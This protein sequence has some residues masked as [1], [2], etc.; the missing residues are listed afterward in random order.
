MKKLLKLLVLIL[1][2]FFLSASMV[3]AGN[4]AVTPA[5]AISGRVIDDLEESEVPIVGARVEA[6]SCAEE[7]PSGAAVTDKEGEYVLTIGNGCYHLRIDGDGYESSWYGDPPLKDSAAD[8]IVAGERVTGIDASISPAGSLITGRVKGEDGKPLSGAWVTAFQLEGEEVS[9][10]DARSDQKGFF[11]IRV[12]PGSYFLIFARRGYVTRVHGKSLEDPTAV[13]VLAGGKAAGI[14]AVLAK[15]GRITGTLTDAGGKAVDGI[16]VVADAVDKAMI[17]VTTRSENGQFVL[18]GLPTGK[19][20]IAFVD[21]EQHYYPQWHDGKTNPEEAL[22]IGVKAPATTSGIKGVLRQAG[23]ISGRVTNAAGNALPEVMVF[24][25][26]TD[27]SRAVGKDLTDEMGEYSIALPTGSYLVSFRTLSGA[28]LPRFYPDGTDEQTAHPVAVTAP[29]RTFGID[30]VLPEGIFLTG[31]VKDA[32]GEPIPTAFIAAYPVDSDD[33]PAGFTVVEEDGNFSLSLPEGEYV[34]EFTSSSGYLSQWSGGHAERSQ[35]E[36]VAIARDREPEAVNVVLDRGGSISGIVKNSMGIG[37]AGVSVS[38]TNA[39]TGEEGGSATSDEG[40]AFIIEGLPTA[41]FYLT[42]TGSEAGYVRVR[43]PQPVQVRAPASTERVEIIMKNGGAIA[44]RIVDR[45]GNP[46]QQVTVS[47]HDPVTWDEIGS[48]ETDANGTYQI[49]GLP[50]NFYRIRFEK[51]LFKVQWFKGKTRREDST[52]VEVVGTATVSSIDAILDSGIPLTGK[53][54]DSA[55]VPLYGAD[56]EIYG[57]VEDEPFDRVTTDFQGQFTVPTLAAGSY[58]VRFGH[59]NHVPQ[60]YGGRDRRTAAPVVITETFVPVLSAALVKSGGMV[61]GKLSS[62]EGDDI[63]EAWLTVLDAATGIA[64]ADERICECSGEFDT[65]VPMGRYRLR[66]ERH[67]QISWYGGDNQ[68]NATVLPVNGTVGRL[69]MI[70]K[71]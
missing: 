36:T 49:G 18:D 1:V 46:M 27:G 41:L 14:D 64:V 9:I 23:G 62:P 54:T 16:Y 5:G 2:L 53:I 45:E 7:T 67:G 21:N 34:V 55:G 30:Q 58:R 56:V 50:E 39:G 22:L 48:T 19:Y 13:E 52:T 38:A 6:F 69:N 8:V 42:A 37:I 43:L 61:S 15:G 28:Q 51:S 4:P 29:Q 68:K 26:S 25:R 47:A 59:S 24:A 35:A 10:S 63:G 66:V 65:P 31:S 11:S 57:D 71:E 60:W 33:K 17:P 70:I 3:V 20:T 32:D 44:G 40:G 12:Y